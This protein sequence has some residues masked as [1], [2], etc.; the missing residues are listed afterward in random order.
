MHEILSVD[1]EET[2]REEIHRVIVTSCF[3]DFVCTCLRIGVW[4]IESGTR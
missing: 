1:V 4:E 2:H 3:D